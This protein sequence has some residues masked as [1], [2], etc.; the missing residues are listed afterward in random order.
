[1]YNVEGHL[2]CLHCSATWQRMLREQMADQIRMVN[3]ITA[4]MEAIVGLPGTMPRIELPAPPVVHTGAMTLNNIHVNDS[5]VG[6]INT[7][8]VRQ[9]DVAVDAIRDAGGGPLAEALRILSQAVL[10]TE[11]LAPEQKREAVEHLAFLAEQAVLPKDQRQRSIGKVVIGAL[12]E[13]LNAAASAVT[14]WPHVRPLLESLF[15]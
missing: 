12:A 14:L 9:L 15:R 4:E 5:V 10:D 3:Y 8:Q 1:M 11:E 2:L 6:V 7:G 13:V